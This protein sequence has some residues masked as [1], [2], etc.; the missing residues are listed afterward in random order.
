MDLFSSVSR[1]FRRS[2]TAETYLYGAVGGGS[3]DHLVRYAFPGCSDRKS[4]RGFISLGGQRP[5]AEGADQTATSK[6]RAPSEKS[7]LNALRI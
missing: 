5:L 3:R 1:I 2:S 4:T 7:T 6:R